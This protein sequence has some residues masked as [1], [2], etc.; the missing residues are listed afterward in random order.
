MVA[1][2]AA[3]AVRSFPVVETVHEESI[4]LLTEAPAAVP[5]T[6]AEAARQL[7]ERAVGC[8]DGAGIFG[9]ALR[10]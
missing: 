5:W 4:L 6:V 1:R 7:A 9:C 3:G 2:T 10:I 8:L